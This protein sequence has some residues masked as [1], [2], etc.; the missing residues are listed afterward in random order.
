MRVAPKLVRSLRRW[1][2][3]TTC[4]VGVPCYPA[5]PGCTQA[6]PVGVHLLPGAQVTWSLAAVAELAVLV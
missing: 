3:G 6:D 2:G 5:D 1:P 4:T